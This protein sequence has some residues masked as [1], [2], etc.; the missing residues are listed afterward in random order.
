MWF[1]FTFLALSATGLHAQST[2]LTVS[3]AAIT[4]R[5]GE[6]RAFSSSVAAS[7]V[8]WS[9]SAGIISATGQFTAPAAIPA[10]GTVTVR[11]T[12]VADA[13][14]T[15]TAVVTLQNAKPVI[16]AL[17][18]AAVN[19]GLA[20]TLRIRGTNF[21]PTSTVTLEGKAAKPRFVS[22]TELEVSAMAENPAGNAIDVVVLNP[23]PGPRPAMCGRWP[24]TL[25]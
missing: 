20:Y 22:A 4:L 15:T 14:K 24:S 10:G 17:E 6:S 23:D 12:L 11:A 21:L 13:T 16:S 3:P 5:A 1:R 19:T 9:A 8:R 7:A 25:R 18:P 2:A